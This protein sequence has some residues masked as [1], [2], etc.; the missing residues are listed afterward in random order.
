M[1]PAFEISLLCLKMPKT[2]TAPTYPSD[3]NKDESE[4]LIEPY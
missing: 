1:L 2:H 4:A 3:K